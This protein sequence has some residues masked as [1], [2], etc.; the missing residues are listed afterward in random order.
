MKTTKI[1]YWTFTG[2]L[3]AFMISS[4][5]PA[6]LS[7]PPSVG[8]VSTHLG[9]PAYFLP[10]IG[11]AKLLGGVALIVPGFPKIKE[12]AYAGFTFDLMGAFYSSISVHDNMT[13]LIPLYVAFIFLAGSYIWYHKKIAENQSAP[14]NPAN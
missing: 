4:S 8:A 7:L 12:W 13:T 1:I 11:V 10:F 9:Y 5:I 2:L 3:A 14:I 6:I